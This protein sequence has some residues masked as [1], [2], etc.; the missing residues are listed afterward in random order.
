[1]DFN[2][3][4]NRIRAIARQLWENTPV[5]TRNILAISFIMWLGNALLEHMGIFQLP[6]WL[7][8]IDV[9]RPPFNG[10]GSF[11][12]WQ[13]ITYM[14]MHA[15]FG[16]WFFNMLAVWMFG[17]ALER[18]W[19]WKK[20]LFYYF[21]C[22]I[23]AAACQLVVWFF[24]GGGITVGASGAVFGIL[25]AFAWIFPE[26]KMFLLFIPIPIPSRWFVALYALF[27]LFGGVASIAGDNIAHFAHLGGLVTGLIILWYWKY[28][29]DHRFK[30]YESKD[31]SGYHYKE[32]S[33]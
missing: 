16:H 19:G 3:V 1:M 4:I 5:V 18:E 28:K 20:Y 27:E 14:F 33:K 26:Q 21:A 10:I 24:T 15:S 23:G 8:L 17:M 13:P 32:P 30:K 6:Y 2:S 29:N 7:G 12:L 31:Y 25:A 11:H 9:C 22:G